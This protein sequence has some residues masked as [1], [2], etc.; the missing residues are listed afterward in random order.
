[1]WGSFNH[2]KDIIK[3]NWNF[4][5]FNSGLNP[6]VFTPDV[7]KILEKYARTS[8]SKAKSEML[9]YILENAA[10]DI[11][12][13]ELF[14]CRINHGT[15]SGNFKSRHEWMIH[16]K[17][18]TKESISL[19][20]TNAIRASTD[21][22]HISPD[23]QYL[24]DK[25]ISGA[26]N[27]MELL[28]N[29]NSVTYYAERIKV[30]KAINSCFIRYAKLA[31]S[32]KT[33]KTDFIAKNM[34]ALSVGAP[35]T[36]A[37]ALQLI[38]I[39]YVIQ[40]GLD[41]VTV[42]SLGGLDRMLL[43]FYKNDLNT[44]AFTEEQL[45]EIT[46]YFLWEI[47]CMNVTANLPFYMCGMDKDGNDATNEL[48]LHILNQ[49]RELDVYDPKIHILYHKNMDSKVLN[50]I[51]E[52][53]REGKNSFVF[54]NT[55]TASKALENIGI[56]PDDAKRITVYGCY[57]TAAEGT[58]IPCTC[59]GMINLA[60]AVE[61]ALYGGK[62]YI[63]DELVSIKTEDTFDSFDDFFEAVLKHM[64]YYTTVCMDNISAAKRTVTKF[65]RR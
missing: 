34:Y 3:K 53:I 49:Y 31:E 59:G 30:Y 13:D 8:V 43:P 42:R 1:M 51:L 36:Y 18:A 40:T 12:P 29:E 61:F 23:W 32:I 55:D 62:D 41:V 65:V 37:Q 4:E 46:K 19:T 47:G 50:L 25:G 21:F 35:K 63:N 45:A 64:E 6:E 48:T 39:F 60:K 16:D 14:V 28:K 22:G 20:K 56:S 58:E 33:P 44:G 27:D 17:F 7:E 5:N 11:M 9:S 54:I 15:V 52:M 24:I 26:I 2:C 57:E 10:I 38:L